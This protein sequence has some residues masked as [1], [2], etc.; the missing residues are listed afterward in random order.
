MGVMPR[1]NLHAGEPGPSAPAPKPTK[2][3]M[4]L[5]APLLDLPSNE[6]L[7]VAKPTNQF[8]AF[9][10]PYDEAARA[11]LMDDMEYLDNVGRRMVKMSHYSG[12]RWRWGRDEEGNPALESNARMIQWSDGS[13]SLKVGDEYYDVKQH[14]LGRDAPFLYAQLGK[15]LH[16]CLGQ[17]RNNLKF[18]LP[19]DSKSA[20]LLLK[21][22]AQVAA[23]SQSRVGFGTQKIS[24]L[25]RENVAVEQ[26]KAAAAE[27][28]RRQELAR[29]QRER[30]SG[31]GGGSRA[32]QPYGLTAEYLDEDD[33]DDDFVVGGEEDAGNELARMDR[34]ELDERAALERIKDAKR[35]REAGDDGEAHKRHRHRAVISDD[36]D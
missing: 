25:A 2:Q 33:A 14:E 26:E 1:F 7:F 10:A 5:Q 22:A 8:D 20:R 34:D 17:L 27:K 9:E 19:T 16:Q 35:G 31:G 23:K 18:T 3:R 32:R 28:R 36:E 11:S 21:Q 13:R 12:V 4:Q 24:A 30:Q 6:H 15:G 29:A